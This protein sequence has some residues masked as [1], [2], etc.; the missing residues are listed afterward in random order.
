[1]KFNLYKCESLSTTRKKNP[2]QNVYT[3]GSHPITN[4]TTQKDLGVYMSP[5]LKWGTH[6]LAI[7]SKAQKML[8]HL[9]TTLN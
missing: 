9:T 5:H 2:I 3:I 8:D 6:V 4:T 1:M 7:F